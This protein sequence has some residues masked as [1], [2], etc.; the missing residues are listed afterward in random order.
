MNIFTV[1]FTGLKRRRNC[2]LMTLDQPPIELVDGDLSRNIGK[3][4]EEA[5]G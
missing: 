4:L 1:S 5:D 3:L 2:G